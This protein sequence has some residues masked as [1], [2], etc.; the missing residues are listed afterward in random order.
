MR[1]ASLGLCFAPVLAAGAVAFDHGAGAQTDVLAKSVKS[2]DGRTL[3]AYPSGTPELTILRVK[4]P[5]GG[6][7]PLHEHPVIN[8]AVLLSGEIEVATK[9]KTL[10]LKAGEALIEVVNTWHSGT[11]V[12]KHTAELI[13]FYAGTPDKPITV[14][15]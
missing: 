13:I 7:L 11:N 9:E 2:W 4:I 14:K 12:G 6:K 5:P 8:A 15:K 3:P 1:N 10:H